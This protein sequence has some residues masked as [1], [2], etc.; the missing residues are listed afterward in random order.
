MVSALPP[1][2]PLCRRLALDWGLLTCSGKTPEATMASAM[3]GDIKRK[4][5]GSLFI[6]CAHCQRHCRHYRHAQVAM[7]AHAARV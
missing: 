1:L 2:P 4:D 7:V 3:Y 5:R 6:R